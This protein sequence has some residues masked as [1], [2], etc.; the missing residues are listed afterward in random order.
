MAHGMGTGWTG[1]DG[2]LCLGTGSYHVN[3]IA[4]VFGFVCLT[5]VS[6]HLLRS[7]HTYTYGFITVRQCETAS[8]VPVDE[9]R[10]G[11]GLTGGQSTVI[12]LIR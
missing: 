7:T 9:T 11:S 4:S 5:R 10:T 6:C 1:R 3:R 2:L 8:F 12:K